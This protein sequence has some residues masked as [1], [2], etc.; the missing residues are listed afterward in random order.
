MHARTRKPRYIGKIVVLRSCFGGYA[1]PPQIPE[2]A[3]VKITGFSIGHFNV[4]YAGNSY[5][6]PMAC[7]QDLLR[8]GE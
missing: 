4:E 5:V 7:V 3:T 6:V 2:L 8:A 1:L